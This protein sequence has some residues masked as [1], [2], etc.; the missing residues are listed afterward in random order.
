MPSALCPVCSSILTHPGHIPPHP[1][2]GTG[3]PCGA[4]GLPGPDPLDW[5]PESAWARRG[6]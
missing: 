3:R 1:D 4:A 2:W 6:A 5:G